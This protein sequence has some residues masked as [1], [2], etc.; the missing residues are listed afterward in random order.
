MVFTRDQWERLKQSKFH[1]GAAPVN[2][3][4]LS[5]N[6]GYVFALPSRYNYAFLKG[7]EEVE[8][9]IKEG[10]VQAFDIP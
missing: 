5:R 1:I 8:A 10:A 2:P 4:E 7:Y 3:S 9:I 6:R